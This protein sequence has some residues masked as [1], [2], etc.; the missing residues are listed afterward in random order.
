MPIMSGSR[1]LL[2]A[3]PNG[4]GKT[5][6]AFRHLRD[7]HGVVE[8]VN[9]DEISRGL[10]PLA[11]NS[12]R[13]AAARVAHHRIREHLATGSSFA[14]E[15]TLAGATHHETI[16]LAHHRRFEVQILYLAVATAELCIAR[17]ARRVAEGGH[18]VPKADIRRRFARS[19]ARLPGY[20]AAVDLWRIID[21][22]NGRLAVVAEGRR[23]ETEI[24]DA[25]RFAALR[26]SIPG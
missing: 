19:V 11:P 15:T 5:T 14:I 16:A 18:D 7:A 23:N 9:L 4:V 12:A 25:E 21:A 17:V 22:S 10:S 6:Y 1:L 2:I 26:L 3:G 8:F 20:L 24:V 13:V